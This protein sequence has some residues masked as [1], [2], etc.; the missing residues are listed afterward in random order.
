LLPPVGL[1]GLQGQL[2]NCG[3]EFG[4]SPDL[5][6]QVRYDHFLPG[7]LAAGICP[8]LGRSRDLSRPNVALGARERSRASARV[9]RQVLGLRLPVRSSTIAAELGASRINSFGDIQSDSPGCLHVDD[10]QRNL[11]G[12]SGG[13]MRCA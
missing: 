11:A 1:S 6:A 3:G 5:V 4:C 9:S 10:E 2:A 7:M 13:A 12:S 8:A